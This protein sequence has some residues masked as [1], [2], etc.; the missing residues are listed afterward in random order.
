[1]SAVL[2]SNEGP[3]VVKRVIRKWTEEEDNLM[4]KLVDEHGTRHWG[5][6]GSKIPGR[7]GKQCRERWHN[8]LDPAISKQLWTEEEEQKL[9]VLHAELGNRWAEVAKRLPGRTDNAIK[10]HWNSAK[11]R[12]VRQQCG[13]SGS[14]KSNASLLLVDSIQK[15][16]MELSPTAVN[17]ISLSPE[18]GPVDDACKDRRTTPTGNWNNVKILQEGSFFQQGA[19]G[20]HSTA[21]AKTSKFAFDQNTG[22]V[23]IPQP[24]TSPMHSGNGSTPMSPHVGSTETLKQKRR[25]KRKPTEQESRAAEAEDR[26]AADMLLSM[27]SPGGSKIE[28][29][30]N[31]SSKS[32][33]PTGTA[34]E[35][36]PV[37]GPL[38]KRKLLSVD[39][40]LSQIYEPPTDESA[41]KR[42]RQSEPGTPVDAELE[43]DLIETITSLRG[44]TCSPSFREEKETSEPDVVMSRPRSLSALADVAACSPRVEVQE[45]SFRDNISIVPIVGIALDEPI[46]D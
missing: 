32:A 26:N 24:G 22:G 19:A 12:L 6:I 37:G 31:A 25:R 33:E 8:Q 30:V 39:T 2:T 15:E 9:I 18:V 10:N 41:A 34:I 4:L 36:K 3:P 20:V 35:S 7:T 16:A 29:D 27:F 45:R 43:N 38:I 21:D 5:L 46:T 13:V 42:R 1:M 23:P 28:V 44:N 14:K 17:G 40:S 11:R